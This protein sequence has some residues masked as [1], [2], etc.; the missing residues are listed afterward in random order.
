VATRHA[1][2]EW[3]V[4]PVSL[5]IT[6]LPHRTPMR[7]TRLIALLLLVAGL[8]GCETS[9]FMVDGPL[10]IVVRNRALEVV[11]RTDEP[12]YLTVIE[13]ES[14]NLIDWFPCLDPQKCEGLAPGEMR[15]IP[16]EEIVGY[17]RGEREAT[18]YWWHLEAK[19]GGGFQQDSLRKEIIRL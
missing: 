1:A 13:R 2:P 14:S 18:L 12:V 6:I 19:S 10:T 3:S 16:Y 7:I 15:I 4:L 5:T 9:P 11:N 8:S 17:E